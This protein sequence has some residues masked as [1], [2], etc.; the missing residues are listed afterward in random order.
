M[1]EIRIYYECLEQAHCYIKP[2]IDKVS[3][4]NKISIILI[5]KPINSNQNKE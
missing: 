1:V 4:N 2:F 5:K 3:Q